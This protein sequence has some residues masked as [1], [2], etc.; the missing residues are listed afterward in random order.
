[1]S[2][3]EVGVTSWGSGEV[4]IADWGSGEVSNW[5]SVGNGNWSSLKEKFGLESIRSPEG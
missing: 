5:G 1:V 3:G 4:G 2:T